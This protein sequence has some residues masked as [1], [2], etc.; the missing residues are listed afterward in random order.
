VPSSPDPAPF[1]AVLPDRADTVARWWRSAG[2]RRRLPRLSHLRRGRKG[3]SWP[4]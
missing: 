3:E 1:P 2:H 4:I